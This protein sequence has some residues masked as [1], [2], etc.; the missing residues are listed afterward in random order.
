MAKPDRLASAA[1]GGAGAGHAGHAES[2]PRIVLVEPQGGA[3][4]GAVCRAIKN[5]E[6]GRLV[7]VGGSFDHEQAR[8]MAV[9]AVDVLEQRMVAASLRDAIAGCGVV[10]GTTARAGAYRD[11]TRD[12][13]ELAALLLAGERPAALVFGPEDSGLANRDIAACHHLAFV[14]TSDAYPSLNLSQ[15]VLLCLYE[16]HRARLTAAGRQASPGQVERGG[17]APADA[18]ALE[19]TFDQLERALLEIGFLSTD[20]PEH[21]MMSLRGL[22]GRAALDERELRIV[23]GIVRQISWFAEGGREVAL[24]K[25]ERG[26]KLK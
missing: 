26:E 1:A 11:R 20:N 7:T 25:R 9:H 18:A 14:A 10:V 19:D 8:V 24:A 17:H 4:V 15:A 5:M 22:L 13:R 21:I 3:N 2:G 12:I 6:G 23:R 16:V